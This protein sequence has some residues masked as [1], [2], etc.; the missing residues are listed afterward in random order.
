LEALKRA[1]EYAL[2][3][4]RIDGQLAE[5][6]L[7]FAQVKQ[8][9]DRDPATTEIDYRRALALNPNS[10]RARYLYAGYLCAIEKPEAAREQIHSALE[11][12]PL[13]LD[14]NT[15]AAWQR[16]LARDFQGA[17]EQAWRILA[18]EPKFAPAQH[19]LGLAYEQMGMLEEAAV[20]LENSCSCWSKHPM[21]LAALAH[22][23]ASAGDRTQAT[24][25]LSELHQVA[26]ER[27][28]SPYWFAL[29]HAG[30][31]EREPALH[32]L[33][34]ASAQRDVWT[35]WT[36]VDPRFAELSTR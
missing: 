15:E 30:L 16:Y 11:L 35:I 9:L 23:H 32:Y 31:G 33:N 4:L 25:L 28:V 21:P 26:S 14:V 7:S 6:N 24:Q 17:I 22:V 36:K 29:V 18:M 12:D 27:H 19:I 3:A 10:A 13:S 2:A 1:K 8:L 5:A 20:E 34:E